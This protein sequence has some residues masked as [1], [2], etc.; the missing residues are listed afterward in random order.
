MN[1]NENNLNDFLQPLDGIQN[2]EAPPFL[3]TRIQQ[4]I[5]EEKYGRVSAK[6]AYAIFASL[7]L[8]LILNFYAITKIQSTNNRKSN[9]AEIF[10]IMPDNNLYQ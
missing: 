9:L 4:R 8:L 1:M 7:I 3:F 2:V 6:S 10:H 5:S